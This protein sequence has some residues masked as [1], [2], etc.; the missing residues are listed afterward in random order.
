[1]LES[2]YLQSS[3]LPC[4]VF[5]IG[6]LTNKYQNYKSVEFGYLQ[7]GTGTSGW[8]DPARFESFVF[9]RFNSSRA[10]S[11]ICVFLFRNLALN[12][13]YTNFWRHIFFKSRIKWFLKYKKTWGLRRQTL[14]FKPKC[15]RKKHS[16]G[17]TLLTE[18]YFCR[19]IRSTKNVG[20]D[21]SVISFV[22]PTEKAK[23]LNIW[24]ACGASV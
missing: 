7:S 19:M 10:M 4:Y 24:L 20:L 1:M 14:F 18:L 6:P 16:F 21:L 17:P 13:Q 9:P 8:A 12:K 22:P 3:R 23:S 15:G 11:F 2:V 5:Y